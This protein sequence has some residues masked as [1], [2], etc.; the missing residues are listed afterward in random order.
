MPARQRYEIAGP[1]SFTDADAA[2][3]ADAELY[4]HGTVT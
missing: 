1:G 3:Y 2:L 4:P